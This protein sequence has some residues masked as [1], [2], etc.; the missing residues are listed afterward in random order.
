MSSSID[1]FE[2]EVEEGLRQL[3][4]RWKEEYN[5]VFYQ[6]APYARQINGSRYLLQC[7][8]CDAEIEVPVDREPEEANEKQDLY[9][10]YCL[11][12]I[13]CDCG[14]GWTAPDYNEDFKVEEGE[15]LPRVYADRKI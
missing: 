2:R 15:E 3:E 12:N 4:A 8:T 5:F 10:I 13:D 7:Q 14:D 1:F 9:L 11:K 6:G